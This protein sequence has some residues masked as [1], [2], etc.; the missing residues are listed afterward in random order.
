MRGERVDTDS[1]PFV[2]AER[3]HRRILCPIFPFLTALALIA[4]IVLITVYTER[5]NRRDALALTREVV[6]AVEQAVRVDVDAYLTPTA[7]SVRLLAE[8]AAITGVAGSLPAD[9]GLERQ[10]RCIL[11]AAVHPRGD[12]RVGLDLRRRRRGRFLDGAAGK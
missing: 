8:A 2:V 7:A 11:A 4:A 6:W 9:R 3:R 1:D 10:M 12:A 5:V